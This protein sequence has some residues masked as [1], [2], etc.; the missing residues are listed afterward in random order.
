MGSGLCWVVPGGDRKVQ[1]DVRSGT[2]TIEPQETVTA[3]RGTIRV[4]AVLYYRMVEPSPAIV[5]VEALK[6]PFTKSR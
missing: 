2:V 1:L 3:D 6:L 4:N 5:R